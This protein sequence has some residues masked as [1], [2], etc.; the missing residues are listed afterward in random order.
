MVGR[1]IWSKQATEIFHCI[2]VYYAKKTGSKTYSSRLNQQIRKSVV[3]LKSHPLIGKQTEYESIHEL[4]EGNF[5]I[6]YQIR[7]NEIVILMIWDNRQ[8]PADLQ[9]ESL[10]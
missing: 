2:L 8:N 9:I 6:I 7:K 3:R 5:K 10:I 4:S 1:I